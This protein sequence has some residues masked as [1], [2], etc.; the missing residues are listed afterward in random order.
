MHTYYM[1][2]H[3]WHEGEVETPWE[4]WY[5]S[6]GTLPKR[7]DNPDIDLAHVAKIW[8]THDQSAWNQLENSQ[9]WDIKL[10]AFVQ[11]ESESHA[12]DQVAHVFPD[13]VWDKH[14]QVDDVTKQQIEKLFGDVLNRTS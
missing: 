12:K 13:A 5:L 1:S 14:V 6:K 9:V 2:W 7:K 10:A 8:E 4:F 3:T 11:A